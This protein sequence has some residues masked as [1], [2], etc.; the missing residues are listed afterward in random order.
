VIYLRW[1]PQDGTLL[2]LTGADRPPL[3]FGAAR[4]DG[5]YR[6]TYIRSELMV[7]GVII[8]QFLGWFGTG[9]PAS[10]ILKKLKV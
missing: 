9:I 3:V 7:S 10:E 5:Q 4:S 6:S 8:Y 2:A 1:G